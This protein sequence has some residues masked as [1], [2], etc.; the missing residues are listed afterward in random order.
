VENCKEPNME[1][2]DDYNGNESPE[3]RRTV[4]FVIISLLIVGAIY[5]SAHY[6]FG[7][8]DDQIKGAPYLLK[9][10]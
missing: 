9:R 5:T 1:D 10:F 7:T 8:V 2:I 4:N 3:K 6:F